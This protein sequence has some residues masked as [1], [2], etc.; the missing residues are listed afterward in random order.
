[1]H[2]NWGIPVAFDLFFAGLGAGA[3]IL[4]VVA[5][6]AGDRKNRA[7]SLTGAIIAPWPVILGVLLLVVDLGKPLRFWEMLLR[8]G[9]GFL[10]FNPGSVMSIGTWLLTI[11]VILSLVYLLV[12]VLT[13]PF[14]VGATARSIVGLIGLPFAILVATYTG[15]L[16]AA[17]AIPLW[18]TPLLPTVFVVSAI[19]TGIAT[20]I[21]V[22]AICR[23]FGAGPEVASPIPGLEKMNSIVLIVL[24][25]TSL[26]YVVLGRSVP[27]MKLVT[28]SR[29]M[30]PWWLGI[31]CLGMII[32]I[33]SGLKGAGKN[34]QIALVVSALVLLGGFFMRYVILMA[35][36]MA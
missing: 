17:T 1:M 20:V 23:I 16:L 31:V 11:F 18:Q 36:Q 33:L 8:V 24:L 9:D 13:I 26:A 35:G 5:Q 7:I 2:V 25:A 28:C 30:L 12:T 34:P 6:L 14:N 4:A 32:P 29:F 3:F 15:V 21:F 10:M 22:L 19:A 27:G